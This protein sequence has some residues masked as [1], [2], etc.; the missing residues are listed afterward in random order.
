VKE[1]LRNAL[2]GNECRLHRSASKLGSP[3][4][5]MEPTSGCGLEFG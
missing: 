1:R 5:I 2:G 3:I 4:V